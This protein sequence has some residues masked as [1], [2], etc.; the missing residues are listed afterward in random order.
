MACTNADM[1]NPTK[2]KD[3]PVQLDE[4]RCTKPKHFDYLLYDLLVG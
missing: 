1:T 3:F 4:G 2:I